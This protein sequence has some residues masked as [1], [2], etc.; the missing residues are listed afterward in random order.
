MMSISERIREIRAVLPP[1]VRLVAVSKF[2]PKEALLEA[3]S[4]GQRIFGESRVQELTD[5]QSVLPADIEWHFIGH[6]QTNK[7]KYIVPFV[8][9]IHGVD[10]E[11]LLKEIDST[12]TKRG[13]KIRCLLQI[14]IA[15]EET[16][17]GFSAN[18]CREFLSS[19]RWKNM[20]G[21][22]ICG[23]MGMATYTED[24]AQVRG[25][26]HGLKQL[27][28]EVKQSYFASKDS[29]CEL[30]MG[31]SDDYAIAIEEGSTLVRIGSRIFGSR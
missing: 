14:H 26:F 27:F 10:S 19:G 31:M 17:F 15:Q 29:F 6:L 4:A 11:K 22:E 23:L 5:K 1:Q 30:S 28:D 12:A 2:H 8:S 18:E 9:L 3:Y 16:K 13:L 20:A 21:V 24:L 7:I 25:E